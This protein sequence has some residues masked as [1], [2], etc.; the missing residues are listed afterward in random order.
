MWTVLLVIAALAFI[1]LCVVG[2]CRIFSA[3]GL[4]PAKFFIPFYGQYLAYDIADSGGIFVFHIVAGALARLLWLI[5][6]ADPSGSIGIVVFVLIIY[7]ACG[8]L[9]FIRFVRLARSY[10]RQ[11]GF[12]VGLFF[13]PP[14]FL[15]IL[16]S[17][18]PLQDYK[19]YQEKI[20][21]ALKNKKEASEFIKEKEKR[22]AELAERAAQP[23]NSDA[24]EVQRA[25]AV[26]SRKP[27]AASEEKT[28]TEHLEYALKFSTEK[29]MRGYLERIK[30]K[31]SEEEQCKLELILVA[32][33]MKLR[34]TIGAVLE[35]ETQ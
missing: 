14:I 27:V 32:S 19:G 33:D 9:D 21:W 10:D 16:A 5:A 8:I 15:N 7:A 3:V 22:T 12:A 35:Q 23:D 4:H 17:D 18:I 20:N 26:A 29:G 31:C 24:A 34:E 30:K 6:D 1:I 11:F 13:L 25:D 2:W 28:F